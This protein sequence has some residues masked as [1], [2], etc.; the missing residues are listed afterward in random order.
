MKYINLLLFS[1]GF[2][3]L[4]CGDNVIEEPDESIY[5]YEFFPLDV[6]YTWEYKVDSTLIVQ[7]GSSNIV[8][9]SYVQ[10]RIS[11]LLSEEGDKK[12][13]RIERSYKSNLNSDWTLQDVWQ[14]SMD[15]TRAIKTEE[16]LSFI[17]LIF[18][19]T[20]GKKWDGN[21]FFDSNKEF[22]V[23]SNEIAIFQDWSYKIE[24]VDLSR[25]YNEVTYPK[26][27]FV[28]HTDEESLISKRLSEEY[29]AEGVGL[30]ERKMEIFDTQDGDT[31]K[32]WLDRAQKGFQLNQTLLT[33]TK[34]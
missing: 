18:P 25:T 10:E 14:V 27:L 4:S 20:K 7:G 29:Y 15:K 26:V 28:S 9:T 23:A 24:E 3:Y 12:T 19:A 11:D 8:G 5:G 34:N 13:Y 30:V 16:N 1:F 17:K 6:G 32:S 21:V 2:I 31:S 33:F 22:T